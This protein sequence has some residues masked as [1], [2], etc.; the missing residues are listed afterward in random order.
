MSH[1]SVARLLLVCLLATLLACAKPP[2]ER[3][4]S[5]QREPDVRIGLV[6]RQAE[7]EL[8]LLGDHELL[9]PDGTSE[10]LRPGLLRLKT[11]D[12][13]VQLWTVD[14]TQ[15]RTA[16]RFEVHPRVREAQFHLGEHSYRGSL[17]IVVDEG[18][19]TLIN[20][21]PLET[22][23]RGVVPWE[24][25][26]RNAAETSAVEAQAIAARTYACKRLG[27]YEED[28]YD[29]LSSVQDQVY[30]GTTREDSTA[31]RAIRETRGMVLAS[32]ANLIEA[33]YSSTCG[34]HTSR[35]EEVWDKPAETYLVGGFDR[36]DEGG[37][38]FCTDSKH[39]RWTEA[40]S[41]ADIEQVLQ[42]TLPVELQWSAGESMG[43]LVDLRTQGRD[44]SGRVKTLEVETPQ[45]TWQVHGD[46]IRWVLS[47]IGR[48]ILRSILF[49]MTV[50][51]DQ[52]R[53]VRVE[54]RGG[55][56]GHGV[57]M[58]QMGAIEMAR[59]G[60]DHQEILQH[61]YP[62]TNLLAMY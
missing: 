58:C 18:S 11:A 54:V 57:G 38:A 9:R 34:G 6:V 47:P 10:L 23:L 17:R 25:G 59:R 60:Y 49:E 21:L 1:V 43:P 45:A 56:N 40:W 14:N 4:R 44:S 61:Y 16:G 20:V 35:I 39:F 2:V 31:N 8:G 55:G 46:R 7:V 27:Q 30:R 24:I 52:G 32:D 42:E 26:W 37:A 51:R 15:P 33:Y 62:H 12:G 48:T 5:L 28:G 22:Y 19:L 36:P 3:W 41:G 13:L 50:E 53:I 29:L